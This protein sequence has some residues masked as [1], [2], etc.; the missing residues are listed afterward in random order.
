M[1]LCIYNYIIA[2]I[3]RQDIFALIQIPSG[4]PNNL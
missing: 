2:I 4:L 1:Q 3:D